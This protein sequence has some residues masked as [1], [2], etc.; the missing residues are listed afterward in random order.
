MP[1]PNIRPADYLHHK[2][3]AEPETILIQWITQESPAPMNL[4][5]ALA[6]Y[7]SLAF[8]ADKAPTAKD[9]API[10]A[11]MNKLYDRMLAAT[12][13]VLQISAQ[14]EAQ[15][16]RIQRKEESRMT[17]TQKCDKAIAFWYAG[18]RV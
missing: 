17:Y 14:A 4:K 12:E 8:A 3:V 11:E 9:E 16:R 18:G 5:T 6:R 10:A 13:V 1:N 7:R 2:V 15:L